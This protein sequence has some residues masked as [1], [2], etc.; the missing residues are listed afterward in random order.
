MSHHLPVSVHVARREAGR[1]IEGG[2]NAL[3]AW[4]SFLDGMLQGVMA[5][6][7]KGRPLSG[8]GYA[9][10]VDEVRAALAKLSPVRLREASLPPTATRPKGEAHEFLALVRYGNPD[11]GS[12]RT[13]FLGL[14]VHITRKRVKVD[15]EFVGVDITRHAL[16]R[17][18]ERDVATGPEGLA[19]VEASLARHVGMVVVWRWAMLSR[20]IGEEVALPL[21][22][23]LLLGR[24]ERAPAERLNLGY[25]LDRDGVTSIEV[26]QNDFQVCLDG[27]APVFL[28]FLGSTVVDEGLLRM[29]QVDL[30]DALVAYADRNADLLEDLASYGSWGSADL[31][32]REGFFAL[33]DRLDAAA[34]D[35][36]RTLGH[37]AVRDAIM[38]RDVGELPARLG[39]PA[40]LMREPQARLDR[41]CAPLRRAA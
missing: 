28:P 19:R 9:A 4:E 24:I 7:V 34:G 17:A 41:V 3:V 38:R 39:Y 29:S 10:L 2:R 40:S 1:M 21:G 11:H 23:G 8:P 27:D 33:R 26:R 12:A 25:R 18:V 5:R 14:R 15:Q 6:Y 30:R 31:H 32:G 37:P 36:A 20:G 22:D 13:G 35:L 16:E